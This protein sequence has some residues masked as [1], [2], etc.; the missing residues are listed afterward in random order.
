MKKLNIL[1][2]SYSLDLSKTLE[3]MGGIV[4]TW[5]CDRKTLELAN[6]LEED[7]TNSTLIHEI[8]EAINYH[9]E[10]E[11]KHPQIMALEVGLHQVFNDNGIS[12][13][14]LREERKKLYDGDSRKPGRD[15]LLQTKNS[16]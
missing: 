8:L 2:Y 3:D 5:D 9:L 15:V 12:L 6:D 1:G 16:T 4:G 11:L 10:L 7:V 14:I 13:N